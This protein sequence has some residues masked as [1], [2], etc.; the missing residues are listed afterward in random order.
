MNGLRLTWKRK[1]DKFEQGFVIGSPEAI[2]DLYWQLTHNYKAVDG[3][4][5]GEIEVHNLNG[6]KV[7]KKDLM[8]HPNGSVYPHTYFEG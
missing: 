8:Q 7:E 6:D 2:R 4:E 5:I 3:T 1:N